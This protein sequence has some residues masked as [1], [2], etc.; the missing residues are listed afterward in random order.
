[1]NWTEWISRLGIPDIYVSTDCD[2]CQ[3]LFSSKDYSVHLRTD[4]GWWVVDTVNDRHQRT[5]ADAKLSTFELA[6]KYLIWKWVT[7]AS[8]SLASGPLG[9]DL[10]KQGYGPGI[11]VA[12]VDDAHI[13]VCL[14]GDCAILMTGTA[15]IF[16]HIMLKSVEEIEQL[17][18]QGQL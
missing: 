2:D 8:P 16:S 6:E 7:Q 18:H 11:D 10:Y 13:K 17:G 15:T 4:G 3:V 14:E 9:A 5:I 1:M 12:E